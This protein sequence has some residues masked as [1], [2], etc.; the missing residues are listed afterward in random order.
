MAPP[1]RMERVMTSALGKTTSV[2]SLQTIACMASVI[3]SPHMIFFRP[4]SKTVARGVSPG[5]ILWLRCPTRKCKS[6]TGHAC[7]WSIRLYL[8]DFTLMRFFC[9]VDNRLKK[10]AWVQ[11]AVVV[12][13]SLWDWAPVKKCD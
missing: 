1:I 10:L 13:T 8:I 3:L 7:G 5:E 6:A 11:G 12:V 4:L 9:L 2:T